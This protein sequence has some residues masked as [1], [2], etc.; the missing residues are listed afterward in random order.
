MNR[1][2]E[3]RYFP[4]CH[5]DGERPWWVP[6]RALDVTCD[7]CGR[8]LDSFQPRLVQVDKALVA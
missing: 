4:I 2:V 8:T 5:Q 1:T 7:V 3:V 6:A